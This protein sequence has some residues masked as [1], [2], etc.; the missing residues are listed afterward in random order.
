MFD[1]AE[2]KTKSAFL[3]NSGRFWMY[4]SAC[5]AGNYIEFEYPVG[6]KSEAL[7]KI[8]GLAQEYMGKSWDE[9]KPPKDFLA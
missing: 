5:P 9:V 7:E 6:R 8:E 2:I 1:A 3:W 4:V